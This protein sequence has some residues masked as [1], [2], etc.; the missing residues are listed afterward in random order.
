MQL[1][2]HTIQ[3]RDNARIISH[4]D[5]TIKTTNINTSS[6]GSKSL[7]FLTIQLTFTL[8]P[9]ITNL[10]V[11]WM[12]AELSGSIAKFPKALDARF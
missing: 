3:L 8:T 2:K 9:D 1:Q 11:E 5:A 7:S 12:S 10:P 4:Y 6:T